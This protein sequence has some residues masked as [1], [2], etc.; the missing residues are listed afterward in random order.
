MPYEAAAIG[1]ADSNCVAVKVVSQPVMQR[2]PAA[3]EDLTAR[4]SD[5]AIFCKRC[6][7][8]EAADSFTSAAYRGRCIPDT[9][10][11]HAN[12][13]DNARTK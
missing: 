12:N 10:D 1:S 8:C 6:G 9:S 5:G 11:M 13:I 2:F 3:S 4:E 7:T